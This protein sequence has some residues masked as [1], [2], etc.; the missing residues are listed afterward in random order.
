MGIAVWHYTFR[1]YGVNNASYEYRFVNIYLPV[2]LKTFIKKIVC[3]PQIVTIDDVKK[4]GLALREKEKIHIAILALEAKKQAS[5]L[6]SVFS[7]EFD[8][9]LVLE[10][11]FLCCF[12]ELNHS[13]SV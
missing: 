10:F 3:Y 5:L 13:L 1:L 7:L 8:I 4:M 2:K 12:Y 9:I 11:V 6:F